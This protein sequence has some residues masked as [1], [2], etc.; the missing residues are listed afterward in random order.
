MA[1]VDSIYLVCR[2]VSMSVMDT[3]REGYWCDMDTIREGY[4]CGVD[5]I[6]EGYGCGMGTV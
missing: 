6:C 5:T 3:I 1:R 4:G 2:L